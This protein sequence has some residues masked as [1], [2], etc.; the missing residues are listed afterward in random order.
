MY[1]NVK[2]L[3]TFWLEK[4]NSEFI[5]SKQIKNQRSLYNAIININ[6][7][8]DKL[9]ANISTYKIDYLNIRENMPSGSLYI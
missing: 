9:S 1:E 8:L 7:Y 6:I 3:R 5:K 2:A 4:K